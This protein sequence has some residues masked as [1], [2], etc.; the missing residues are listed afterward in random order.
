ML[1]IIECRWYCIENKDSTLERSKLKMSDTTLSVVALSGPRSN[2]AVQVDATGAAAI[3]PNGG[4]ATSYGV[5][6]DIQFSDVSMF[7]LSN[8]EAQVAL[9]YEAALG[10]EPDI[11]G[12]ENWIGI[13]NS[14]PA[15]VQAAGVYTSLAETS[16]G[17][18]GSMPIA[19]GFV[20]SAE[21]QTKYGALTDQAYVTQLYANVLH[22]APDQGGMTTWLTALTPVGQSYVDPSGVSHAG[23]GESRAYVLVGFAES[24]ENIADTAASSTTSGTAGWL[25]NTSNG[26]YAD[27]TVTLP[28]TTVLNQ[29]TTEINSALINTSTLSSGVTYGQYYSI[30]DYNGVLS[31]NSGGN[32]GSLT[33]STIILSGNIN[34]SFA[35]AGTTV[36]GASTGGSTV[37]PVGAGIDVQF[38]GVGNSIIDNSYGV[39]GLTGSA[40]V[41]GYVP[42]ADKMML[43]VIDSVT[44][45]TFTAGVGYAIEPVTILAPSSSAPVSGVTLNFTQHNYVLNVGAVGGG[46]A[47]EVATAANAVYSVADINGNANA[48]LALGAGAIAGENLTIIGET[49]SG[50]TVIYQWG[51][52][53]KAANGVIGPIMSADANGN[54]L[55]D[56]SELQLAVTLIGVQA[57]SLA[58]ADFH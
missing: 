41:T 45:T 27:S 34:N 24:S 32:A 12:L 36:I 29:A 30:Q 8:T 16:G 26:G 48:A 11:A 51:E 56:A 57:S 31:I 49:S 25:I 1:A 4:T 58:A 46:T 2:Y 7:V 52:L 40:I 33:N 21:F 22:R 19:D 35:F 50:N 44:G 13:Y 47:A 14:L 54:H 5:I 10:R 15:S 3:T 18:N 23:Q 53:S 20:N 43:A 6:G 9:L 17:F 28:A 55:I 38:S 39:S 37:S 42:G